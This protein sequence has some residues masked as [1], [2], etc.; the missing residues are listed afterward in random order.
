MIP[1]QKEWTDGRGHSRICDFKDGVLLTQVRSAIDHCTCSGTLSH[2]RA[3]CGANN[4]QLPF[5]CRFHTQ[6]ILFLQLDRLL[7]GR[8][9]RFP[10]KAPWIFPS[11]QINAKKAKKITFLYHQLFTRNL[12][13][14]GVLKWQLAT[15][16]IPVTGDSS[17]V[18]DSKGE[19]INLI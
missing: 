2:S 19:R 16:V 11:R 7:P 6:V 3:P 5:S 4:I 15:P 18:S 1:Q 14:T 8:Q 9:F 12:C 10:I 17:R 13:I